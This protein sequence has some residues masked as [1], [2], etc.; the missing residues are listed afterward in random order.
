MHAYQAL[1]AA[2]LLPQI[3][4]N[5]PK[6]NNPS[7]IS[8]DVEL[9]NVLCTVRDKQGGFVKGLSK[10]DFTLKEDGKRQEITHFAREVDSPLMVALLLDVSGS[11]MR[12]LGAEKAA[13]R[14][15]L[16]EVIRRGDQAMLVGF[17]QLIA[18]WQDLTP[19]VPD[20]QASLENAGP[21]P[22]GPEQELEARPRGGTL[23]YD[24]IALVADKKLR[25]LPGRKVMVVIT[26]GLD[27]GSIAHL[28][29]ALKAAQE[30]D[31]VI[32][33]IHYEEENTF[34][35]TGAGLSAMEH[36]AGP[37]GGQA[38]HVGPKM[39]LESVFN[40]IT[41]EMR[42]QYALGYRPPDPNKDGRFHKLEVKAKSGLKVQARIGYYA[43]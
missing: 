39:P 34:A 18:V 19:S 21:F 4:L 13:G 27:N 41:E 25:R 26:D 15:F 42:N 5:P 6:P 12:V 16:G 37:T 14:R 22:I 40:A 1:A 9:V 11:V 23:L 32:Y 30:A 38:F 43:R 10:Q 7:V 28:D 33:G 17:A 24:A 31:A 35:N 8:V 29:K 20:L 3:V 36:L 2:L